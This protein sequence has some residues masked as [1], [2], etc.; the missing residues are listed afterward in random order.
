MEAIDDGLEAIGDGF[1][2][3]DDRWED[4]DDGWEAAHLRDSKPL[5]LTSAPR[6]YHR[7][8]EDEG[9]QESYQRHRLPHQ[10]RARYFDQGCNPQARCRASG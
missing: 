7:S 6:C 2:A 9:L 1:G 8:F 3:I 4:I 10:C 5:Y